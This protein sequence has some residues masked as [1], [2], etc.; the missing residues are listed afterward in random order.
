MRVKIGNIY[1]GD[2]EKLLF[3]QCAI[4]KQ[5]ILMEV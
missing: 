5:Q 4:Q 3:S 2:G 1:I